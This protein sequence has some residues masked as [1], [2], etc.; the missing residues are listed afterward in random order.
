VEVPG[1][2]ESGQL[3]VIHPVPSGGHDSAEGLPLQEALDF[4]DAGSSGNDGAAF[5]FSV[6]PACVA[7]G[8]GVIDVADTE[9]FV[10]V[11]V[12]V[13]ATLTVGGGDDGCEE[14]EDG[15]DVFHCGRCFIVGGGDVLLLLLF[16]SCCFIP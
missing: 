16:R 10:V 5:S 15:D 12:F 6:G 11:R 3:R 14:Q 4:G 7:F 2:G 8:E 1:I 9:P 13:E